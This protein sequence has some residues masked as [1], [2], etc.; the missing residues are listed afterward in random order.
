[1]NQVATI[2]PTALQNPMQK[3]IAKVSQVDIFVKAVL[4]VC[5]DSY[6]P[7]S[8]LIHKPAIRALIGDANKLSIKLSD[9]YTRG[10]LGRVDHHVGTTRY[11]YGK[12]NTEQALMSNKAPRSTVTRVPK[13]ISA[14]RPVSLILEFSDSDEALQFLLQHNHVLKHIKHE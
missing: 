8:E 11:A 7:V 5:G 3:A 1:M 4:E 6:L 14:N 2:D 9:A 13:V 12:P 10:K